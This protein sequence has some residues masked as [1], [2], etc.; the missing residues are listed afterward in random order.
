MD[1]ETERP[2]L[3]L[4]RLAAVVGGYRWFEHSLFELTGRWA[5]TADA[6]AAQVHLDEVSLQHAWHADL[7]ADRVPVLDR[8]D[9]EELVRPLVPAGGALVGA[10]AELTA[11]DSPPA[12]LDVR[13]L[14]A[15]YRVAVPRILVTYDQ[16]LRRAVPV[17]DGPVIRALRLV[18]RDEVE[19][20]REGES[21]LQ[22]LL[23]GSEEVAAAGETQAR[24]E[25]L[26]VAPG[27]LAG[28]TPWPPTGV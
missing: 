13:R 9:P 24:L 16:H 25:A 26:V 23:T 10:M 21:L 28:L 17:S 11:P 22:S 20:W 14:A 4:D 8:V 3:E 7:W 12:L 18:I 15:L 6:P 2:F 19:S 1:D 27:G 5:A